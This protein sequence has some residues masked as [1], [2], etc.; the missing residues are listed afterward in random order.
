[1]RK[2]AGY[3]K[4]PGGVPTFPYFLV[5]FSF[6]NHALR[7]VALHLKPSPYYAFKSSTK[8]L[9]WVKYTS[10]FCQAVKSYISWDF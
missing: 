4:E 10:Q 9:N 8:R 7:S 1:M 5:R 6:F 2:E 3:R